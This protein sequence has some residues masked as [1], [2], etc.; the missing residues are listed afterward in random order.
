MRYGLE[1]EYLE[2]L[3]QIFKSIPE[4]E[5]VVLYGSR[6]RGDY[7]DRS[8]IDLSLKGKNLTEHHLALFNDLYYHSRIPFLH[9]ANLYDGITSATFKQNI[10]RDGVTIYPC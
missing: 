6:A 5:A 2:A 1:D 10:D 7:H 8:D 9:D 4:I 3:L